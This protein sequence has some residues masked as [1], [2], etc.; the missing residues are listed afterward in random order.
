MKTTIRFIIIIIAVLLIGVALLRL[1]PTAKVETDVMTT[2]FPVYDITRELA[3]SEINVQL[4]LSPGS[5]PHTFEPSP[6]LVQMLDDAK[7]VYAIGFG[8][9][10]WASSLSATEV[11]EI[12]RVAEELSDP[13]PEEAD[14][15]HHEDE[16]QHENEAEEHDHG[17]EDPHYWLSAP[18]AKDMATFIAYDLAERFP[19]YQEEILV[20]LENYHFELEAADTEIREIL[21]EKENRNLI[22]LHDSWDYFAREYDLTVVGTFEPTAGRQ[23]TPQYLVEL[24]SAI[25]VSGTST[26]YSE[27]QLSTESIQSFATD[28]NLALAILDPI[29]G[30]QGRM[31]LIDLLLYNAQV[32]AQNN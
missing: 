3:P 11:L 27:P 9:D 25:E 1:A 13:L 26:I 15:D 12:S 19:D 2:I 8:L 14:D 17:P 29:G 32:I 31:S 18:I 20:N 30:I 21:S 10:D 5:S 4:M 28:N 6:S 22:T 16:D 7:I 23:P 24:M